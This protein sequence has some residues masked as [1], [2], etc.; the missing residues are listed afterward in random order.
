MTNIQEGTEYCKDCQ[1]KVNAKAN[2]SYLDS[3]LNSVKT[4]PS[5]E[6]IYK[7]KN[8][9]KENISS[10]DKDIHRVSGNSLELDTK[11]R[12]SNVSVHTPEIDEDDLYRVDFSD[13]EDFDQ[14][15]FEEDI[16]D[17]DSDI[18]INDEDLFG[19]SLSGLLGELDGLNEEL[20]VQTEVDKVV[21]TA[22]SD[23]Q[24][25]NRY[26]EDDEAFVEENIF[27]HEEAQMEEILPVEP[28][29]EDSI[30]AAVM[31]S[32]DVEASVAQGMEDPQVDYS[33]LTQ[34]TEDPQ[35]GYNG[36]TQETEDPQDD[37]SGLSE[38]TDIDL[39][40]DELLN[41]LDTQSLEAAVEKN[42]AN[43][44]EDM[45]STFGSD[46]IAELLSSGI[47]SDNQKNNSEQI[48]AEHDD[49]LDLLGQVSDEDMAAEDIRAIS[50]M[51]AGNFNASKDNNM[52]SN[53]G[54]VFSDALKAVS[55]LNDYELAEASILNDIPDQEPKKSKKGK[56]EKVIKE[57]TKKEKAADSDK[58]K[59]T[60]VQR[61]FG[62]VKDSKTAAQ[63]E[64]EQRNLT[65]PKAEKKKKAK[66]KDKNNTVTSDEEDE[67][68][69]EKN[70]GKDKAAKKAAKKE[71]A[72]KKKKTKEVIEVIDEIDEDQGR[73]N[74]VGA[75]IVF[76]FF[77]IIAILLIIGTNMITYTLSVQHATSY[78]N[79]RK[80]NQAYNEVY[81]VDIRDEDI[82][83]YDK[84]QTV[85]FVNK[86]LNSYNNNYA[87]G[88]YP[89]ALDSLLKGL[90]RYEKY[91]ELAT[92]LGIEA[93]LDYV[94]SQILAEL[95][96]VFKLTEADAMQ[97]LSYDNKED[98][99][100][101]VYDVV[102]E[103]L[104]N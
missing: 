41:S 81:G 78:F 88:K 54:E 9:A 79:H 16:S 26:M 35:M 57:K 39:D 37:Y 1:D 56:K 50:E 72:E 34:E 82:G 75:I 71:K 13:I 28:K 18:I 68:S 36:L 43:P 5:V 83:L 4:N 92:M 70:G 3:L 63:F 7:K 90:S 45:F 10:P 38:D 31:D 73:I 46:D 22:Y 76:F 62:N 23:G 102:L 94:R 51:L 47:S 6:N 66:G 33:G 87:M 61:L 69:V 96:N 27:F 65:E 17:I 44:D 48:E 99:S 98:Y 11:H 74:R 80:Y 21:E 14:F 67:S 89:E 19:D 20:D 64:E 15:D 97:I 59:L 29:S 55:S 104:N 103:K 42:M 95:D 100:L 58:P 85:M 8:S 30:A 52:P 32:E 60:L 53:V 93:D 49:F 2:E 91:I 86:Q 84:I 12:Q 25:A 40:L 101:E 24:Q 77:G